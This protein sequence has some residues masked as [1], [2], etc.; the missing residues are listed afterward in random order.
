MKKYQQKQ[1]IMY[2][3]PSL[4]VVSL[5]FRGMDAHPEAWQV[6]VPE[7]GFALGDRQ[8]VDRAPGKDDLVRASHGGLP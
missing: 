3:P 8:G 4:I 6:A 5:C 2:S 1:L 7:D